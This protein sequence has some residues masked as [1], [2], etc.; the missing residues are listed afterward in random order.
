MDELLDLFGLTIVSEEQFCH[1][2]LHLRQGDFEALTAI[3][4]KNHSRYY[5]APE[6]PKDY[7]K[8]SYSICF[9]PLKSEFQPIPFPTSNSEK[10]QVDQQFKLFIDTYEVQPTPYASLKL[11]PDDDGIQ[12]V[13]VKGKDGYDVNKPKWI[14]FSSIE[15]DPIEY[16]D[17]DDY[18]W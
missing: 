10:L 7:N 17:D 8:H 9:G 6:V 18:W 5:Q 12:T 2:R 4:L 15:R 1:R 14:K 11:V 3:R 13:A 16:D